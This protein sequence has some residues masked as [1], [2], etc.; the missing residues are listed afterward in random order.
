MRL[1][2][3]KRLRR[4]LFSLF[5]EKVFLQSSKARVTRL[6]AQFVFK[7]HEK[8]P[9]SQFF[10]SRERLW[11]S[12]AGTLADDKWVGF[13]FGVA[14]GDATRTFLKMSF[15]ENC[16]QWNGY[17]TFMGLPKPWGDLPTGAFSTKGVTPKINNKI[18]QW[19]VGLIEETSPRIKLLNNLDERFVVIFDFDLYS[20]TK[21]AWEEISNFLKPGDIVYFDEAY[22][23]DE[24]L[25][26]NE[27]I[28]TGKFPL[29]ALGYTT[30]GIAFIID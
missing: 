20:A 12:F 16:L 19:H 23:F 22:E 7:T 29:K 15:A 3:R 8:Y 1:T 21:A 26:I 9:N 2:I 17:D 5:L 27:I 25:I 24:G 6:S 28:E 30:M 11:K 4:V 13:E 14:S 10:H 18:L